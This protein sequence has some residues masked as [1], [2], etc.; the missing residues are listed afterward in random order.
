ML[1]EKNVIYNLWRNLDEV[2]D[3]ID[4]FGWTENDVLDKIFLVSLNMLVAQ[5]KISAAIK[6]SLTFQ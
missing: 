4:D 1:D 3:E 6:S 5:Y 2:L